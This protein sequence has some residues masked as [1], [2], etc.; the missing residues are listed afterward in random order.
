MGNVYNRLL[1]HHALTARGL[2]CCKMLLIHWA[3][4]KSWFTKL[5]MVGGGGGGGGGGKPYLARGLV[6]M[7]TVVC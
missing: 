3:L 4:R 5:A 2:T 6:D 1:Q 7:F